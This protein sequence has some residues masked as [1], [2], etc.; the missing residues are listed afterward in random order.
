MF[1]IRTAGAVLLHSHAGAWE[2]VKLMFGIRTAGAVLLHSHAGAWER[3]KG[4]TDVWDSHRW[5]VGTRK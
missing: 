2:R 1:G 3:V 5:R 4:E